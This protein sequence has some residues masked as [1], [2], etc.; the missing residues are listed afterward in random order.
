MK[1]LTMPI[2]STFNSQRKY[3]HWHLQVLSF[4]CPIFYCRRGSFSQPVGKTR[5]VTM[6]SAALLEKAA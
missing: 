1:V 6:L 2:A 4:F 3:F 5:A